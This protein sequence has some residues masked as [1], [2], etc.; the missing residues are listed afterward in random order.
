M[1]WP[2]YQQSPVDWDPAWNEWIGLPETPRSAE[3]SKGPHDSTTVMRDDHEILPDA[4]EYQQLVLSKVGEMEQS[5]PPVEKRKRQS[6][7][8]TND[9]DSKEH[10]DV[11][12]SMT[13][14][15]KRS[16]AIQQV[17]KAALIKSRRP[18]LQTSSQRYFERTKR[19]GIDRSKA[20]VYGG[21]SVDSMSERSAD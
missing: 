19:S 14:P 6:Q 21:S 5:R 18:A 20:R 12:G 9:R 17:R 2:E 15:P 7:P 16:M 13:R 1:N 3:I 11:K 10:M 4:L 8:Q